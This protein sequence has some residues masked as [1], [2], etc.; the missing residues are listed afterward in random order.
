MMR[1]VYRVG[2][3]ARNGPGSPPQD[4]FWGLCFNTSHWL[5]GK[6]F[7]A[8]AAASCRLELGQAPHPNDEK[9]LTDACWINCYRPVPKE[10]CAAFDKRQSD[11]KP[12]L[13]ACLLPS[14]ECRH[15]VLS[16]PAGGASEPSRVSPSAGSE[17]AVRLGVGFAPP[18]A[19]TTIAG[20]ST[21]SSIT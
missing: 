14:A 15:V 13:P 17:L 12:Q 3:S 20:R 9:G 2:F 4:Q 7:A 11:I 19:T 1:G 18:L 21:R 16:L 8:T 10:R 5:R 6:S